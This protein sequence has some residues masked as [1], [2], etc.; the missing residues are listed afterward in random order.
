[1]PYSALANQ[2][3]CIKRVNDPQVKRHQFGVL[4]GA[5]PPKQ[6]LQLEQEIMTCSSYGRPAKAKIRTPIIY[7]AADWLIRQPGDQSEDTIQQPGNPLF[8]CCVVSDM[9]P[10]A[11]WG[12]H[13]SRFIGPVWRSRPAEE[14]CM[15]CGIKCHKCMNERLRLQWICRANT[16]CL[17]LSCINL[18]Q[19]H[20]TC[21]LITCEDSTNFCLQRLEQLWVHV[22][23]IFHSQSMIY[24][25]V[26]HWPH[27]QRDNFYSCKMHAC[28]VKASTVL[29]T[30]MTY[31]IFFACSKFLYL[32]CDFVVIGLIGITCLFE[33]GR[34][35]ALGNVL[36]CLYNCPDFLPALSL[37]HL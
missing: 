18:G 31:M 3:L 26:P 16:C 33:F 36:Y 13:K 21:I 34:W 9:H 6:S 37:S 10:E 23:L 28:A 35:C 19:L 30:Y 17:N 22:L 15:C 27:L 12:Y 5:L 25:F 7:E 4:R 14:K 32:K 8:C 2:G 24:P 20:R 1:M 29:S 11:A